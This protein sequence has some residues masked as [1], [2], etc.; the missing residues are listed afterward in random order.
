MTILAK[1]PSGTFNTSN[2]LNHNFNYYYD[3]AEEGATHYNSNKGTTFSKIISVIFS[4]LFTIFP[5]FIIIFFITM[6]SKSG[7][8]FSFGGTG[9]RVPK[10]V[11]LF[12]DIPCKGDVF[13]TY[14][15]AYNYNLMKKKED[16]LGAILLKWLKEN[17]VK[18]EKKEVGKIF[19]KED[20]CII[21]NSSSTFNNELEQS[22]HSMFYK[23]SKDGILEE[24][25]FEKW[26]SSHYSEV[27]GWFDKVLD[28]QR[29]IL[30]QEGKITIEEKTSF[31][32]FKAKTYVVDSSL[33][34]E[35]KEL[36]GLKK[37]LEE[38]TLI[39]KRE[40]IEVALFE[41][42]LIFAQ[43]LGIADKV[44]KQ[45]KKLYPEI[46]EA[47]NYDFND[48]LLIHTI[49]NAG[50]SKAYSARSRAQSYSSGG[51]RIFFWWW[52]EVA[53]LEEV[54]VVADFVNTQKTENFLS[55]AKSFQFF[56]SI[57]Q[58]FL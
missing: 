45:F 56:V 29:D 39:D 51:R 2:K 17:K 54:T 43:I 37:F 19:K 27:L 12:R 8:K 16:F 22:L 10:D 36:K 50:I 58:S 5:L 11:P 15:I 34:E 33:M 30:V 53:H 44:A 18:I 47:Y 3:M 42:Y 6:F 28:Y 1:F 25:E 49:S 57:P 26:C 31:K 48:I 4:L 9:N 14:F 40:A 24:K 46:I 13:R 23:A 55:Q 32:I 35:A 41:E 52:P 38:F 7:T 21:L 20:T